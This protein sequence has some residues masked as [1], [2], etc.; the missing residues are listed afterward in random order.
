MRDVEAFWIV[1]ELARQNICPVEY[2]QT[3]HDQQ[4]EACNLVR[5][6]AVAW[7]SER[8]LEHSPR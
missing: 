8:E 1:L 7:T 2:G 6:I 5:D 3:Y 4:T